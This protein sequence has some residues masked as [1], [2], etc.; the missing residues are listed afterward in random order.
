MQITV[1]QRLL[2]PQAVVW[3]IVQQIANEVVPKGVTVLRSSHSVDILAPGVSKRTLVS[4]VRDVVGDA[5]PAQVLCIGD[6]GRWPGNDFTLLSELFSLSVDEVSPD[7]KTCW[8][9][10]SA[11]H[12]GVQ[13]TL[14]YL[15]SIQ[16]LDGLL[17]LAM[18]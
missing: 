12:R 6:R 2:A 11:G 15:R 13:A 1:Q 7:P 9:L 14:D 3:D 17:H 18:Q 5:E 4:R 10:A 8:N 16:L